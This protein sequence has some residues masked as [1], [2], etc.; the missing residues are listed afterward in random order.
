MG[1]DPIEIGDLGSKVKVKVTQ[2]LFFLH[3][4]LLIFTSVYLNSLMSDQTEICLPLTYM[5]FADLY[6]NSIKI[7]WVMTSL[8]YIQMS[9]F[10]IL[11]NL[12]TSF[13]VQT[14]NNIKYT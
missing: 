4:S 8:F 5:P 7:K 6:V 12:Q 11:L 2:Y 3:N 1:S 10:Q 13:L 14:I 9:I